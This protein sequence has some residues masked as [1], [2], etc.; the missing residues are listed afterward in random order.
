MTARSLYIVVSGDASLD[1]DFDS[2]LGSAFRLGDGRFLILSGLSQSR[3]YH[4]VKDR[5]KTGAALFVGQLA[6]QPKF[7]GQAD[8]ALKWTRQAVRNTTS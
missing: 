1:I 4:A 7:K 6:A 2:G 5:T 8:G 3:L